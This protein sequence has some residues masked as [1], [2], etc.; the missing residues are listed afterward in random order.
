MSQGCQFVVAQSTHHKRVV[1]EVQMAEGCRWRALT[2]WTWAATSKEG[3]TESEVE[4]QVGGVSDYVGLRIVATLIT[5]EPK[6][7]SN[8]THVGNNS[9]AN[10]SCDMDVTLFS[11]LPWPLM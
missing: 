4:S 10:I 11:A 1:V 8:G 2:G 7:L 3:E 6:W 5:L 9:F